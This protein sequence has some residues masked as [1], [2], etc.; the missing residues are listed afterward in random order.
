MLVLW[1][2]DPQKVSEIGE[3]LLLNT[4]TITPLLHKMKQ[5]GFLEKTRSTDDERVVMIQLTAKGKSLQDQAALIPEKMAKSTN[6]PIREMKQLRLSMW[7]MLNY[8]E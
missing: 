7:K 6:I 2:K 8:L 3:K 1:E 5:K 4:N